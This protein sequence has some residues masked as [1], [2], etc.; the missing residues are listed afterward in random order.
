MDKLSK[1]EIDFINK[2][3]HCD[4]NRIWKCRH[5]KQRGIK[6]IKICEYYENTYKELITNKN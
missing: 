1:R 2:A 4:H 5:P 6:C 3:A